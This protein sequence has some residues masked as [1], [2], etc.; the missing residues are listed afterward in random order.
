MTTKNRSDFAS[1]F[2]RGINAEKCPVLMGWFESKL[3]EI[4]E[5]PIKPDRSGI[6]KGDPMPIPRHKMLL[7]LYRLVDPNL[8]L[9]DFA[10]AYDAS[11]G[12]V[13]VWA[14][15]KIEEGLQLDF[16]V[17]YRRRLTK[18]LCSEFRDDEDDKIENDK[19][20]TLIQYHL[21]PFRYKN[22]L[23]LVETSK[24]NKDVI[25]NVEKEIESAEGFDR[26]FM[27]RR[28]NISTTLSTLELSKDNEKQLKDTIN[29]YLASRDELIAQYFDKIKEHFVK[30][31]SMNAHLKIDLLENSIIKDTF[32]VIRE[33]INVII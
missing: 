21:E 26:I 12:T 32:L 14:S 9:K 16:G 22:V 11:Y 28:L 8:K 31:E 23:L 17:Y 5:L 30:R 19:I 13:R 15:K 4:N 7:A 24:A 29:F 20:A 1:D 27:A 3:K 25:R 2:L 33:I 6:P 18:I 10:E